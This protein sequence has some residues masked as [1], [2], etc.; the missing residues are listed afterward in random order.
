MALTP[1][2]VLSRNTLTVQSIGWRR[3]A[4]PPIAIRATGA[5][6]RI[7]RAAAA[8]T[9]AEAP[10]NNAYPIEGVV[11]IPAAPR[12]LRYTAAI[13]SSIGRGILLAGRNTV[14]PSDRG[15]DSCRGVIYVRMIW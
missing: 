13:S 5:A 4:P 3:V 12:T 9:S 15:L 7:T 8:E 11:M 10:T 2:F 6:E 1:Q 14:I